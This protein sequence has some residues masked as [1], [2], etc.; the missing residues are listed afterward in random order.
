MLE[1]YKKINSVVM[2]REEIYKKLSLLPIPLQTKISKYKIDEKLQQRIEGIDLLTT[3]LINN[4]LD[5]DLINAIQYNPFGKPFINAE[6]DFSISYSHNNIILGFIKNGAVGVDIERIKAIDY[7]LYKEYYS[8]KEWEFIHQNSLVE[9][10]FFKIWTRKEAVVKAI[11][12]GVFFDFKSVEVI[13]DNITIEDKNLYISS[14]FIKN[15]Y[16]FSIAST[17]LLQNKNAPIS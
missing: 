10:N 15:E 13:D 6:I 9:V 14:E 8:K 5:V 11:G 12:K 2:S 4:I 3:A 16:C 1:I 7:K 17:N